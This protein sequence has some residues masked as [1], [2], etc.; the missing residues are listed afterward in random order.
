ME[1]TTETTLLKFG[2]GSI[3]VD[4]KQSTFPDKTRT[5]LRITKPLLR[6]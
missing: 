3:E 4:K 2:S 6:E 5:N 1:V